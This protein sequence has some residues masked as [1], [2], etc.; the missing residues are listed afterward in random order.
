MN[1]GW[2]SGELVVEGERVVYAELTEEELTASA[3]YTRYFHS[4]RS[5]GNGYEWH[6]LDEVPLLREK[7]FVSVCFHGGRLYALE[8]SVQGEAYPTSWDN[9][10]VEGERRRYEKHRRLLEKALS[11][12]PD[13]QWEKPYPYMEFKLDW[14][15]I[16]SYQDPRSGSTAIVWN[17]GE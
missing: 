3:W 11:R 8:L 13:D 7:F 17:Y 5:M 1:T 6:H 9:W 10:T 15:A 2:A 16:I 12:K 4:T 14:G